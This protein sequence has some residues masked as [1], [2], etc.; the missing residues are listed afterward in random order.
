MTASTTTLQ[1]AL[2]RVRMARND[3]FEMRNFRKVDC[4]PVAMK[5]GF[6]CAFTVSIILANGPM[7]RSLKGRFYNTAE[8]IQFV[9]DQSPDVAFPAIAESTQGWYAETKVALKNAGNFNGE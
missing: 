6:D 2:E 9:L 1:F 5:S 3:L 4:Q 7:E 8:G